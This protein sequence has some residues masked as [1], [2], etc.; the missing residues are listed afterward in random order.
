MEKRT[1]ELKSMSYSGYKISVDLDDMQNTCFGSLWAKIFA[2]T[3]KAEKDSN[4]YYI[5]YQDYRTMTKEKRIF[6]YYA[7]A[8]SGYFSETKPGHVT[9]QIE[10]GKYLLFKNIL[11]NHGPAFFKRVYDYVAQNNIEVHK[12]F[13]FEFLPV[14]NQQ[15][16]NEAIIYVGL[17][18]R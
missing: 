12:A 6:E 14:D 16:N 10:A 4:Q 15:S 17:K 7:L 9:L 18:L 3:K 11:S 13:D 1:I 5:G 2:E 8:P